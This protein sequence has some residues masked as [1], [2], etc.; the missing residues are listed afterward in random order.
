VP[1]AWLYLLLRRGGSLYT[2]WTVEFERRLAH[3]RTGAANPASRLPVERERAIPMAD[4]AP[5]RSEEA[6]IKRLPRPAKLA[7]LTCTQARA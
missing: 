5:V 4:C 3:H 2:G 6:R 1:E 7:L